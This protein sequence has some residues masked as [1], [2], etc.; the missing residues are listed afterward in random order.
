M[1]D[2]T[3]RRERERERERGR[4]EREGETE[5]ER[6][7]ETCICVSVVWGQLQQLTHSMLGDSWT[8]QKRYTTSLLASVKFKSA[9]ER[10]ALVHLGGFFFYVRCSTNLHPG[11]FILWPFQA[12]LMVS[13]MYMS[14][15]PISP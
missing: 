1:T 11:D 2:Y 8:A 7:R 10:L 4:G 13:I 12:G 6:E 14:L 9:M 3:A 5:R 15:R